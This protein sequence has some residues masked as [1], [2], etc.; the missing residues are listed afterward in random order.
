MADLEE[1]IAVGRKA[2]ASTPDDHP[3]RAAWLNNLG[4]KLGRRYERTGA[5][6][7]LK[8]AKKRVNTS[9][10]RAPETFKEIQARTSE[11]LLALPPCFSS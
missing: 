1:A 6:A 8:D 10:T 4:I 7:D 5:M 11:S 2:V 3:D 9:H